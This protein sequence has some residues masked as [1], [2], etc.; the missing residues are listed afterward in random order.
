MYKA[1]ETLELSPEQIKDAKR[2]QRN[3]FMAFNEVDEKSQKYSESIEALGQ[4]LMYPIGLITGG[5]GV[6]L[7]FKFLTKKSKTTLEQVSNFT[8]YTMTVLGVSIVP[9]VLMNAYITKEQ[10]K[11]SRVA[12]MMA[13]NDLNDHR[14]FADYNKQ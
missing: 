8:K 11:A 7:G 5:L 6:A 3:T 14:H 12:D 4:S 10:K 9:S 13:I 1:I 2:L